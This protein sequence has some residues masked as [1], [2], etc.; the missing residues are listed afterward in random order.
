[1]TSYVFKIGSKVNTLKKIGPTRI[2]K[3]L[4]FTKIL[5]QKWSMTSYVFKIGPKV[6]TL[7][8]S[9]RCSCRKCYVL[10]KF[11]SKSDPSPHTFSISVQKWTLFK[12]R[13]DANVKNAS[14]YKDSWAKVIHHL[15][16]FRDRSKSLTRTRKVRD[17]REE[18]F[19]KSK[20]PHTLLARNT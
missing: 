19:S 3:M 2:P 15:I 14:F 7:K 13:A 10:Q 17:R 20:Q 16:C 6:N 9:G 5:E 11:M 1:M 18:I 8:K 4:C 12:N